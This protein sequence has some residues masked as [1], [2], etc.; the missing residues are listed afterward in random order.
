LRPNP[1]YSLHLPHARHLLSTHPGK[2]AGA[3]QPKTAGGFGQ[4]DEIPL[5][6]KGATPDE[7]ALSHSVVPWI[8][9]FGHKKP[10]SV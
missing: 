3:H 6:Y 9:D 2:Q 8:T 7:A 10:R 5:T 1:I 4:V